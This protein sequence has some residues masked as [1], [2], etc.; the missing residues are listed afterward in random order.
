MNK[1]NKIYSHKKQKSLPRLHSQTS[2]A[3]NDSQN[4]FIN[5]VVR[6]GSPPF[7]EIKKYRPYKRTEFFGAGDGGRTHTVSL[8][9]DFESVTSA[10][11]ITPAGYLTIIH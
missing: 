11:S 8:P 3:K 6:F 1:L 4:R 7:V 5:A 10:N 9:T 2:P